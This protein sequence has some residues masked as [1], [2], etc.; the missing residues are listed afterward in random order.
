MYLLSGD[1]SI[2]RIYMIGYVVALSVLPDIDFL[3]GIGHRTALHSLLF[4]AAISVPIGV[5]TQFGWLTSFLI[6]LSHLLLDGFDDG[7][8]TVS[9]FW[10]WSVYEYHVNPELLSLIKRIF[11]VF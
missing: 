3:L 11:S 10:P 6:L 7:F 1:L 2:D 8:N 9:W 4:T 5:F